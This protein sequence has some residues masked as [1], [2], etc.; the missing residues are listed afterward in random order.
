MLL[1]IS[2]PHPPLHV[3]ATPRMSHHPVRKSPRPAAK[4]TRA[5]TEVPQSQLGVI[6]D[7]KLGCYISLNSTFPSAS[8]RRIASAEFSLSF[9]GWA[10]L[11]L[12][13][14]QLLSVLPSPINARE[15]EQKMK[16]A[17]APFFAPGTAVS[18]VEMTRWHAL[19][20]ECYFCGCVG[21]GC[22]GFFWSLGISFPS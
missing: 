8:P 12:Q 10:C 9:R 16:K 7:T 4:A 15:Q 14:L 18:S 21:C 19:N 2:F 20:A 6:P 1:G 13:W 22:S 3:T 5:T 11:S 17:H